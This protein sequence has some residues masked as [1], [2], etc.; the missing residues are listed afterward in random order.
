MAS[1]AQRQCL[2]DRGC[3]LAIWGE[4]MCVWEGVRE[5]VQ[6]GTGTIS[7]SCPH[8]NARYGLAFF[9]VDPSNL[10]QQRPV[11]EQVR[12]KSHHTDDARDPRSRDDCALACLS[13][14]C[15][16]STVCCVWQFLMALSLSLER[17]R[18]ER[19]REGDDT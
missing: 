1:G 8:A 12:N 6:G 5:R 15:L 4:M 7:H 3:V 10:S 11:V 13:V 9:S 17:R 16:L 2:T 19:E 14:N 18:G